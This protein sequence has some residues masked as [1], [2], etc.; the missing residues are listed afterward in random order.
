MNQQ[1]KNYIESQKMWQKEQELTIQMLEQ[2]IDNAN[3]MASFH[4]RSSKL[5]SENLEHEKKTLKQG[6][7]MFEQWKKDNGYE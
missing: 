1:E 5:F 3:K 4:K 6:K 2:N 7:E